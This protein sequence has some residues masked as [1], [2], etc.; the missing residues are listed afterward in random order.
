MNRSELFGA[1]ALIDSYQWK[2]LEPRLCS[3]VTNQ[4][5]D[6]HMYANP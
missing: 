2:T 1:A 3:A 6:I 4:F 5:E